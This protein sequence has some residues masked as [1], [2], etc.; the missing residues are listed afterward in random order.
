MTP[1]RGEREPGGFPAPPMGVGAREDGAGRP[2]SHASPPGGV[3]A[4]A[5][6]PPAHRPRHARQHQQEDTLT[7]RRIARLGHT[8]EYDP[9]ADVVAELMALHALEDAPGGFPVPAE[10]I[11]AIRRCRTSQVAGF[12]AAL[13]HRSAEEVSPTR[14]A[15]WPPVMV[16][17]RDRGRMTDADEAL[18]TF[19]YPW[20]IGGW[21]ATDHRWVTQGIILEIPVL[22][23]ATP[24]ER[25]RRAKKL[26]ALLQRLFPGEFD[27]VVADDWTGHACAPWGPSAWFFVAIV[28]RDYA[29]PIN[30]ILETSH[31]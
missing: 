11:A 9:P 18:N 30:P 12:A 28:H 14:A 7:V 6:R 16:F 31:A 21:T 5:P 19:G 15:D 2:A 27:V 3:R 24:D 25:I 20:M 23:S 17:R 4:H 13:G 8:E 10:T 26:D 1:L 29:L 22:R